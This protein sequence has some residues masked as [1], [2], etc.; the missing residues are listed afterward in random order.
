MS[1]TVSVQNLERKNNSR[2]HFVCS[3]EWDQTSV[4]IQWCLCFFTSQHFDRHAV[5]LA[6]AIC[7]C[8]QNMVI[9]SKITVHIV[10]IFKSSSVQYVLFNYTV[11]VRREREKTQC[12]LIIEQQSIVAYHVFFLSFDHVDESVARIRSYILER[13]RAHTH[14]HTV[15]CCDCV[16][17]FHVNWCA[18]ICEYT[19]QWWMLR[20]LC[21]ALS[22]T[23]ICGHV[24]SS[25]TS[26]GE[27]KTCT[28]WTA[29]Y[30]RHS[31]KSI[32]IR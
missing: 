13:T 3:L 31:V 21:T 12:H 4:M 18:R 7:C 28:N 24:V 30:L 10:W 5:A 23:V 16:L 11:L 15:P 14:T 17:K 32:N 27:Q 22:T 8:L 2:I 6:V 9:V 25:T 19:Y 20:I 29:K 26:K 1:L